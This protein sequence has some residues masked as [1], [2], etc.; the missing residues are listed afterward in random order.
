MRIANAEEAQM[1]V[2]LSRSR[3]A[4]IRL[5]VVGIWWNQIGRNSA[6]VSYT[7]TRWLGRIARG[8]P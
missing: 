1:D 6:R 3:V 4:T 5:G 8:D 7:G 2:I